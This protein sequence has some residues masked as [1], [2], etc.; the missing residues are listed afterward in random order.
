MNGSGESPGAL[1]AN[2]L[3]TWLQISCAQ[4]GESSDQKAANL[5][6]IMQ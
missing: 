2:H 1:A 4:G 5:L 6:E 3:E